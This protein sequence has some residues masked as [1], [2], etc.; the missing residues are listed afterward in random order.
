MLGRR[1]DTT[2]KNKKCAKEN[3]IT[4]QKYSLIRMSHEPQR[5][6]DIR[7]GR[8]EQNKNTMKSFFFRDVCYAYVYQAQTCFLTSN[9]LLKGVFKRGPRS[10]LLWASATL[11][12]DI[13]PRSGK[14]TLFFLRSPAQCSWNISTV[15][16]RRCSQMGDW[17]R[18]RKPIY[19]QNEGWKKRGWSTLK[20]HVNASEVSVK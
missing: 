10:S 15:L 9:Y 4:G 8:A 3:V 16:F 1:P 14:L 5:G 17:E 19:K 6:R 2:E 18:R 7:P 20:H 13:P 11:H 12:T